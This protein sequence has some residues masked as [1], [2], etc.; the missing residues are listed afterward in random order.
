M[1]T[2]VVVDRGQPATGHAVGSGQAMSADTDEGRGDR[3]RNR[4]GQRRSEPIRPE[5]R[6]SGP[7]SK[8]TTRG[9]PFGRTRQLGFKPVV[10]VGH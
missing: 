4:A 2:E 8:A 6:H 5:P 9:S 1:A 10:I 3:N 7:T